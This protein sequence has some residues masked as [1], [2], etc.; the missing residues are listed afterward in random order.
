MTVVEHQLTH[1]DEDFVRDDFVE[2]NLNTAG[3]SGRV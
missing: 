2:I 3:W 1:Y